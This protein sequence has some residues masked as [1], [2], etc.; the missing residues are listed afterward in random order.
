MTFREDASR[1]RKDHGAENLGLFRRIALPLLEQ[2]EDGKK[3]SLAG[4]RK[5]A[6]W[7]DQFLQKVLVGRSTR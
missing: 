3:T 2:A 4:K 6:G 7:N 5:M 1:V